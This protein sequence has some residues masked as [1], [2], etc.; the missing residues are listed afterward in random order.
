MRT[1]ERKKRRKNA[2]RERR[3]I[4]RKKVEVRN[5]MNIKT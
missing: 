1:E 4:K 3:K 2:K 5:G